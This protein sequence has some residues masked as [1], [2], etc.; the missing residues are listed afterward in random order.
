MLQLLKYQTNSNGSSKLT[1]VEPNACKFMNVFIFEVVPGLRVKLHIYFDFGVKFLIHLV[2]ERNF[3]HYL[4]SEWKFARPFVS[5]VKL[6]MLLAFRVRFHVS[7]VLI[8]KI[9]ALHPFSL[10]LHSFHPSEA[11]YLVPEQFSF[12]SVSLLASRPTPNL[13]DHGIPLR[14]APTPWPVWHGCPYQ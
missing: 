14:L 8:V 4:I 6:H 12:Y 1:S 7:F 2:S 9:H 11:D 13:E 3:T 5:W 10:I